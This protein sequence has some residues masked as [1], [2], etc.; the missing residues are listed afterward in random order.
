[1]SRLPRPAGARLFSKSVV[2]SGMLEGAFV[3]VA[4]MAV[5]LTIGQMGQ[6][7]NHARAVSFSTLVFANVFLILSLR[8]KTE[9][10]WK[11]FGR[12]N[13]ALPWISIALLSVSAAVLYLPVLVK[14]FH[15]APP[16]GRDVIASA[17]AAALSLVGFEVAKILR[18]RTLDNGAS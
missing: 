9:P 5:Y 7:P 17:A 12:P 2:T 16:H 13:P 6:G 1:M 18:Q 14:I 15:F 10:A 8:S 4:A 3:F 11:I